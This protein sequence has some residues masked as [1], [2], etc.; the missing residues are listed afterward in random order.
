MSCNGRVKSVAASIWRSAPS[1]PNMSRRIARPAAKVSCVPSGLP[2]S[3]LMGCSFRLSGSFFLA[4]AGEAPLPFP[5]LDR[6][7]RRAELA[8]NLRHGLAAGFHGALH[9]SL[10]I[11]RV[12]RAARLAR[13]TAATLAGRARDRTVLVQARAQA[14]RP[15]R[16]QLDDEVVDVLQS[17]LLRQSCILL[18]GSI[19]DPFFE[20]LA[21]ALELIELGLQV[22][23]V[24]WRWLTGWLSRRW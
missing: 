3:W 19:L 16:Q 14:A 22:L 11:S 23:K 7:Y 8:G 4:R 6:E 21:L 12:T 20:Q 24:H 17:H 18:G 9:G 10:H 2:S 1:T 13:R 15:V 5:I